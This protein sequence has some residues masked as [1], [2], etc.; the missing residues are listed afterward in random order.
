MKTLNFV[1]D[2]FGST[3][4]SATELTSFSQFLLLFD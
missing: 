2:R 4:T 3:E 1:T